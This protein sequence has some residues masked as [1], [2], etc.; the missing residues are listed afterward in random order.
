ML[1]TFAFVLFN[2]CLLLTAWLYSTSYRS[3]ELE[4]QDLS[5]ELGK[6]TA[7]EFNDLMAILAEVNS[8]TVDGFNAT[9]ALFDHLPRLPSSVLEVGFGRGD[10]AILV[11]NKF[12]AAQVLGIDAHPQS[13]RTANAHLSQLEHPPSNLRFEIRRAAE[14]NEPAKSYDVMTTTFVNRKFIYFNALSQK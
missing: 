7:V 4:R 12:P 5:P 10:F 6:F 8:E 2:V 3:Y 13:V 14:L 1:G 11:A 9:L